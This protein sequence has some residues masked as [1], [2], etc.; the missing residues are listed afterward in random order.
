M[1][2]DPTI[3][4]DS[5]SLGCKAAEEVINIIRNRDVNGT[6][7]LNLKSVLIDNEFS[8]KLIEDL[9][10]PE[11]YIVEKS[12]EGINSERLRNK[13]YAAKHKKLLKRNIILLSSTAA[14]IVLSLLIFNPKTDR[15]TVTAMIETDVEIPTLILGDQSK[16]HLTDEKENIVTDKYIINKKTGP[17]ISYGEMNN[18]GNITEYNTLIV[19][20]KYTYNVTLSDGSVVT[21]NANSQLRYPIALNGDT[22]EVELE[23]EAFFEISKSDK[24]FIVKCNGIQIRVYGTKFNVNGY[25]S[26][27]IKTALISGSVGI[28]YNNLE[29]MLIP[30]QLSIVDKKSGENKIITT[31][32]SDYMAWMNGYFTCN[33]G[34]MQSLLNDIASWYGV[35]FNYNPIIF[36]DVTI[37]TKLKRSFDLDKIMNYLTTLLNVKFIKTGE[38]KYDVE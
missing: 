26:D 22:R 16:V 30:N 9:S 2:S 20:K 36:K 3:N 21:L 11:K 18:T 15:V 5:A 34:S 33:S 35:E 8:D 28:K 6:N 27:E 38:N 12:K 23:G 32:V 37:D 7:A 24:P 19:P 25:N 4:T 17:Q 14:L 10:T 1:K 13:L 31:D 29:N